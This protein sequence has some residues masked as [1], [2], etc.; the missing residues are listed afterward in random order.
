MADDRPGRCSLHGNFALWIYLINCSPCVCCIRVHFAPLHMYI[1]IIVCI[2][3]LL[4]AVHYN[5]LVLALPTT[6]EA[7]SLMYDYFEKLE[8]YYF[9]LKL[10]LEAMLFIKGKCPL[11]KTHAHHMKLLSSRFLMRVLCH[12]VIIN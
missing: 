4:F 5:C 7:L 10:F 3:F 11:G 1:I 6:I 9:T 12:I 8:K 2:I